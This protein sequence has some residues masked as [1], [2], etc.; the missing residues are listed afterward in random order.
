MHEKVR[1]DQG[2]AG[3]GMGLRGSGPSEQRAG[4]EPTTGHRDT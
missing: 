4:W 1:K 3:A 2:F